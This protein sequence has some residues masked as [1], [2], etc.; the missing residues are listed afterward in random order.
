MSYAFIRKRSKLHRIF[1]IYRRD[2]RQKETKKYGILSPKRDA[3]KR[4]NELKEEIYNDDLAI[5]T[6]VK[7]EKYLMDF[8]E[9]TKQIYRL[10]HIIVTLGYA[11]NI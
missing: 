11:K 1:R 6:N 3:S 9:N 8:L 7:L 2:N 4:L 5:P 10:L